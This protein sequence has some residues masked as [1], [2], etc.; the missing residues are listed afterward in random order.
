MNPVSTARFHSPMLCVTQIILRFGPVVAASAW[1][2]TLSPKIKE[3]PAI[4]PAAIPPRRNC[5]R[6]TLSL[7]VLLSSLIVSFLSRL[8]FSFLR[9]DNPLSGNF[10][11]FRHLLFTHGC[12]CPRP[13]SV[14]PQFT[15]FSRNFAASTAQS[16]IHSSGA[17]NDRARYQQTGGGRKSKKHKTI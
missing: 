16:Y 3:P 5:L 14:F 8:S 2:A 1:L 4:A 13:T 6:L 10:G 7:V 12:I 15:P 9:V 17:Y 11:P